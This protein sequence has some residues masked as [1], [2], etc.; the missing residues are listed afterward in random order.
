MSPEAGVEAFSHLA[1]FRQNQKAL[2]QAPG[3]LAQKDLPDVDGARLIIEH[4]LSERR[5]HLSHTEAKAVV[6][7]FGIP[8]SPSINVR[9]AADALVAAESLGLPVV[10]KISSPD[11]QQKT[12][13]GGV[14]LNI[15]EPQTV[16]TA[17]R[18]LIETVSKAVPDADIQGVTIEPMEERPFAREI[19]IRVTRDPVFG[20]VI[21]FGVGGTVEEIFA[22]T[23]M[24]LPPLND[25]LSRGLIEDTRAARYLEQFRHLPAADVEQ[26]VTVLRRVS[27]IVCE[28][29]EIQTLEINPLLVDD[30]ISI[31]TDVRVS[32]DSRISGAS[33]TTRYGHMAIHP[34]PIELVSRWQL[35]DGT[36][37][38]IRPIRPED[39]LIEQAFV[40][41]LSPESKYMRFMQSLKELTPIMLARFTQIDYNREMAIIAVVFEG[42]EEAEVLGVARY[43][44]NPDQHSCEFALTVSDEL[45]RQGIGQELMR[46]LMSIARRRNIE[47]MEGEVLINNRRMLSLC[48]RLGFH[49]QRD[50]ANGVVYVR[51]HL[52]MI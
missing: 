51:R 18:E 4:V 1:K 52:L 43:E 20:P 12:D 33:G 46:R 9:S 50:P 7:A 48:E 19:M 24:A 8:I 31:A 34:Y 10:M 27:E 6:R 25:Y 39:A 21:S 40:Q 29:P 44:I 13:V 11:I 15:R 36:D 42:S 3:P 14:R 41:N 23:S 35:S 22:D 28:L 49:L 5:K 32:V 2:L 26:L 37:I 38:V 16:R 47:I 30:V 45:Q 17:Y